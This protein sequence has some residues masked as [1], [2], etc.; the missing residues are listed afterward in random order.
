MSASCGDVTFQ[1]AE[2]ERVTG[3]TVV[4]CA[5]G[6]KRTGEGPRLEESPIGARD[7]Q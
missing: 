6:S 5:C 7:K 4:G 3:G 1:A 2:A